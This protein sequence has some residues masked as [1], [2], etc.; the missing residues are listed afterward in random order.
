MIH[1][2]CR[3]VFRRCLTRR[4]E[5]GSYGSNRRNLT[6]FAK[7]SALS[8]GERGGIVALVFLQTSGYLNSR[9]PN[10]PYT[11]SNFLGNK[12]YLRFILDLAPFNN[13]V[14]IR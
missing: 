9:N 6:F 14:M 11:V 3:K 5:S 7:S 8:G 12:N 4:A 13:L 1:S 10:F 2:A